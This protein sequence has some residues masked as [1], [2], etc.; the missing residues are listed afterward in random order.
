M[1]NNVRDHASFEH[2]AQVFEGLTVLRPGVAND[3]FVCDLPRFQPL[4]T[5]FEA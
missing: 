1:L 5:V 3:L 2:A 4:E